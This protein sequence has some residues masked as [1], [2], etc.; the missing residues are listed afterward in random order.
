MANKA[1]VSPCKGDDEKNTVILLR[2]SLCSSYMCVCPYLRRLQIQ[3]VLSITA[4][5]VVSGAWQY[6]WFVLFWNVVV[7]FTR[8]I[9]FTGIKS[10]IIVALLNKLLQQKD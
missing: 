5:I 1:L 6:N 7:V 2:F 4:S 10:I 8:D 3:H 9:A